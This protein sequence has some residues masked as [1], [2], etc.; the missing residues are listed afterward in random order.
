MVIRALVIETDGADSLMTLGT[1]GAITADSDPS[2]EGEEVRTKAF[3]VL[4]SIEAVFPPD[5][6]PGP[7]AD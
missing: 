5:T 1:G 2:D 3:G 4:S 7:A 6:E